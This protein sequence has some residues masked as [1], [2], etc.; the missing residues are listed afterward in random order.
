MASPPPGKNLRTTALIVTALVT[1]A[2]CAAGP[3]TSVVVVPAESDGH[4]GA[5]RFTGGGGEMLADQ[6]YQEISTDGTSPPKAEKISPG[7]IAARFALVRAARPEAPATFTLYFNS[8]SDVLTDSSERELPKVIAE[9]SRRPGADIVL[10]GH[11]DRVGSL[12]DNDALSRKRA[13]TMARILESRGVAAAV[14]QAVGRGEREPLLAT[15]DEIAEARNRRVEV[16]V[17]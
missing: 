7:S 14:V 2:G 3:R 11:T 4:V 10:I 15:G 12:Q 1:F 17:R 13:Q 16:S 8:G 9:L 6:A 5:V